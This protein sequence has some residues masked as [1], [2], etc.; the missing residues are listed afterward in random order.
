MRGIHLQCYTKADGSKNVF[1]NEWNKNFNKIRVTQ[2]SHS[3]VEMDD[4]ADWLQVHPRD[5]RHC[6]YLGN[7]CFRQ[8]HGFCKLEDC[9][10]DQ[11]CMD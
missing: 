5:H 9:I 4:L 7:L 8:F 6:S 2:F 11:F 1:S 3:R 10:F